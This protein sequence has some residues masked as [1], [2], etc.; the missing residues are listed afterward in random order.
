VAEDYNHRAELLAMVSTSYPHPVARAARSLKVAYSVHE[1]LAEARRLGDALITMLGAIALGWCYSYSPREERGVKDWHRSFVGRNVTLGH[2]MAGARDGAA[3]A[4]RNGKSL[5]G[6]EVA[7]GSENSPLRRELTALVEL[8][9]DM[10]HGRRS[11]Q[12]AVDELEVHLL[13]ALERT[14]FLTR[15]KLITALSIEPQRESDLFRIVYRDMTGSE[16]LFEVRSLESPSRFLPDTPYLLY[17]D[18]AELELTPYLAVAYCAK[19]LRPEVH[20]VNKRTKRGFKYTA[21]ASGHEFQVDELV[22]PLPS[23]EG[24]GP[25]YREVRAAEV[26]V[27]PTLSPQPLSP[28]RIDLPDLYGRTQA[29]LLQTLHVDEDGALGWNHHL[30]LAPVTPV[31]TAFGLR[32][33]NLVK[34]DFSLYRPG[35]ILDS[36]WEMQLPQGGWTAKS[37]FPT[38]RPEAT[39]FVLLAMCICGDW[40][41]AQSPATLERFQEI[42]Q[43]DYDH[44]LWRRV[45]SLAVTIPALALL[46]PQSALLAKLVEALEEAAV[47]DRNSGTL[48]WTRLTRIDSA[49]DPA[50]TSVPLTARAVLALDHCYQLTNRALGWPTDRLR[51]ALSW[52]SQVEWPNEIEE[53][54]READAYRPD[55]LTVW[56]FSSAWAARALLELGH[57]PTDPRLRSVIGAIYKS[58]DGGVWDWQSRERKID[59]PIWATLDA[60]RGLTAYSLRTASYVPG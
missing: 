4:L 55:K 47:V 60:L 40:A 53:I 22:R 57:D 29:S 42:L 27:A 48:Y 38:A 31:A 28:D 33:M 2:W 36:L 11:G 9:N 12:D 43:P 41:R 34:D 18:A 1:R 56:H 58:H 15:M 54:I 23:W 19:C 49:F 5:A 44:V 37:Q 8:H 52:L 39:A 6:M 24:Q 7:V 10:T 45:Y 50:A 20:Y 51:P 17:E 35:D 3:A 13:Q 21:F 32:I 16:P 25:G 46:S 14:A 59:R 30:G 26:L